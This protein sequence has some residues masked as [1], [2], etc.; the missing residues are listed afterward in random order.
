MGP[1]GVAEHV[2]VMIAAVTLSIFVMMLVSEP[3]LRFISQHP[4]VKMLG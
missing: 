3:Q 4:T 1:V 2:E